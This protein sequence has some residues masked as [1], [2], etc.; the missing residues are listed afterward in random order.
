M[1][2]DWELLFRMPPWDCIFSSK[3]RQILQRLWSKDGQGGLIHNRVTP[4][5]P[6]VH[7]A[8]IYPDGSFPF[9][10]V[11]DFKQILHRKKRLLEQ[12]G[13][14]LARVVQKEI[15]DYSFVSCHFHENILP[16]FVR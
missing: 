12:E 1:D 15:I 5:Y 7:K 9:Q 8:P 14:R 6:R 13:N 3:T 16:Y 10:A 2:A 11:N 4:I